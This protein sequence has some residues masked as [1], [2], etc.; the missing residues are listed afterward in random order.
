[1]PGKANIQVLFWGFVFVFFLLALT[2]G[3]WELAAL[4]Q[5][6]KYL[7]LVAAFSGLYITLWIFNRI[8]ARTAILYYEETPPEIITRLGLTYIPP[9]TGP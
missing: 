9:R 8:Q 4:A 2:I 3:T 1:M 6:R 5:P 7:I